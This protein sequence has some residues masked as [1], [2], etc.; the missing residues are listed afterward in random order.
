MSK[1][2]EYYRDRVGDSYAT[3]CRKRYDLFIELLA[4]DKLAS[5]REEGCGIGTISR[6]LLQEGCRELSM[7]DLDPEQLE[8]AKEN[9][10]NIIPAYVGDIL[11]YH[12]KVDLIFSHGVLEHFEDDKIDI[13]LQRQKCTSN[14]VIH[15][16]PTDRYERASFGDE[17]LL[18]TE[19]WVNTFKPDEF[20][21]FNDDKDLILIWK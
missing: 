5:I 11:A 9:T 15:Y 13:I 4:I 17:R 20:I 12:S 21:E 14:K 7:F 3:Y 19:Y 2:S 10:M 1:W 8:L 16:V 6:I 18:S